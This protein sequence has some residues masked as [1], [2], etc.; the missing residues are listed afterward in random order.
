MPKGRITINEERCKGCALCT[1]ACPQGTITLATDR[2]NAKGYTPALLSD[3]QGRCTGCALCAVACPDVCITVYR[4]V[5]SRQ[6]A[7]TA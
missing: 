4:S 1:I 5:P 7:A 3:P 6:A 2:V